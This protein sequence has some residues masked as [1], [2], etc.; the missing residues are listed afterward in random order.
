MQQH[1]SASFWLLICIVDRT[2]W[3]GSDRSYINKVSLK[4]IVIIFQCSSCLASCISFTGSTRCRHV[5]FFLKRR[6]LCPLLRNGERSVSE[7]QECVCMC[8]C[9]NVHS[10]RLTGEVG[11]QFHLLCCH[12]LYCLS[13]STYHLFLSVSVALRRS[14]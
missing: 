13:Y 7:S 8:F 1:F 11:Q 14:S 9:G 10:C 5:Q 3:L 4:N 6:R 2:L 12:V